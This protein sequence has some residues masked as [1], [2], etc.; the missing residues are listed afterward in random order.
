MPAP[1]A[2]YLC[3]YQFGS[4]TCP[5]DGGKTFFVRTN[6][7]AVTL[8]PFPWN[9]NAWQTEDQGDAPIALVD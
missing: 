2:L 9:G 5:Y 1:P 7:P 8:V 6:D 3:S 4:R